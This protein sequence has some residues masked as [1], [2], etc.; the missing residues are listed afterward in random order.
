MTRSTPRSASPGDFGPDAPKGSRAIEIATNR[1]AS[2]DLARAFRIFGRP[3]RAAICDCERPRQAGPAADALPH[4]RRRPARQAQVRP[5]QGRWPVRTVATRRWS[6]SCSSPPCLAPRP[7]T[8]PGRPS[9]IS[10][11]A[12]TAPRDLAD[13]LWALINTREFVLEPLNLTDDLRRAAA[14]SR[15]RTDCE[16]FHRRDF[17]R[18]GVAGLLGLSLPDMLR[19]EALNA[20][21]PP[22]EEAGDRGDPDLALG[23]AGDDRHVGPEARRPRGDPRRVPPDRHGRAGR[24]DQRAHAGAGEGDGPLHA[25][26]LARPHDHART[27]RARSTW[28]RATGRAPPLDYPRV[29]SLAARLLPPRKGIPPYVTFAAL[30]DGAAGH[31]SGLPRPG[32]R[33]VRGRGRP[34]QGTLQ[35]HGVSLPSGFT[36][37][38]LESR[39][40]LRDRF[41]RGLRRSSPRR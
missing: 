26:P 28:P 21:D 17:L 37:R 11:R 7:A 14:M 8:R 31:R 38:D 29:G 1:V 10:G 25:G 32:V 40:A 36:P 22:G 27:G 41:D 24:L 34:A 15:T 16:G 3:E 5:A 19:A 13:V 35:S 30:R 18:V 4:D 23:R 6:R 33:P 9:T 39:E 2:P 12:P 20:P